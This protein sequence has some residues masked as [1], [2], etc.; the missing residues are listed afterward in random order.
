MKQESICSTPL[1]VIIA[2]VLIGILVVPLY[3]PWYAC[4]Q[5][6]SLMGV[7]YDWGVLQGCMIELKPGQWV[8]LKNYRVMQS[9]K[10]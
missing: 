9:T 7:R 2:V 4:K 10:T 8:P 1:E 3:A 6:S 5:R